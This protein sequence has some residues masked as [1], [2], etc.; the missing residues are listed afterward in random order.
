MSRSSWTVI[1][2][3]HV[4]TEGPSTKG[5]AKDSLRYAGYGWWSTSYYSKGIHER[6]VKMLEACLRLEIR[7]V[8]AYAFAMDNFKRSPEEVDHLMH[9]AHDKLLE[10][11]RHG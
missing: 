2:G 5:M 1:G 4:A 7:C 8:S 6:L 11:S 3:M 9:L 10:M